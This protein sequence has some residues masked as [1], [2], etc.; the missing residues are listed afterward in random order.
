MNMRRGEVS[1]YLYDFEDK[2]Q[3]K[4]IM[5]SVKQNN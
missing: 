4:H 3:A 1:V 5:E 2:L